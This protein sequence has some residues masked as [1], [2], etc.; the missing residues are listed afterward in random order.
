MLSCRYS[1]SI[2]LTNGFKEVNLY[3]WKSRDAI[4]LPNDVKEYIEYNKK[5]VNNSRVIN[6]F[7]F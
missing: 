4:E 3:F 6:I 5:T 2:L 7:I 1:A